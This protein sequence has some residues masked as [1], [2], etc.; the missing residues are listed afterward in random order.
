M[1]TTLFETRGY[2]PFSLIQHTYWQPPAYFV[3]T[4]AWFRIFGFSLMSVRMLSIMFAVIALLSWSFIVQYLLDSPAAGLLATIL[5]SVDLF[6]LQSASS[7]RMEMMCC[8]LGSLSLAAFLKLRDRS[9]FQGVFWSHLFATLSILTHPVGV[10]YWL[11]LVFLILSFDG[12]KLTF[13]ILPAALLPA[14]AGM[15]AWGWYILQDP[16]AFFDQT[17]TILQLVHGAFNEK[18]LSSIPMVRSLQL[19][20]KYRY[21]GPF[22]LASG[23]S[24]AQRAKALILVTY[25]AAIFGSFWMARK[26]GRRGV[27]QLAVLAVIAILYLTFASPSKFYYY[28]VHETV[29]MAA[30]LA[31][32]L[33]QA[34]RVQRTNWLVATV[35]PAIVILQLGGDLYRIRQDPLHKLYN[36]AIAQIKDHSMPQSTIMGGAEL[37]FGLEHDRYIINDT[38]LGAL[39]G[40]APDVFVMDKLY[41]DLHKNMQMKDMAIY[42]HEQQLL[43]SSRPIYQNDAYRIYRR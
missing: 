43:D 8:G 11:G 19:E 15:G 24:M 27:P 26:W 28:L 2:M 21:L 32:F 33:Y 37:W 22:G 13:G 35:V 38:N 23:V 40:S 18:G 39:S 12:K 3:F 36:P 9:L 4:A 25:A 42:N 41:S 14:L 7:G 31:G 5:I 6:F 20:I 30:C 1:G 34:D 10:L 29:F 16:P 17:R